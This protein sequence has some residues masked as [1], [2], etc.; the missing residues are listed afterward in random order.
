VIAVTPEVAKRI[1][2]KTEVVTLRD[3]VVPLHLTGRIEPDYGREV[4]VSARISG[5]VSNILVKTRCHG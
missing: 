1:D 3:V 5:R 2:L 4:D